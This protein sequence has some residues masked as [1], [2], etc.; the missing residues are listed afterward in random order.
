[1]KL[2]KLTNRISQM[3]QDILR[4]WIKEEAHFKQVHWVLWIDTN[5][6]GITQIT[7]IVR[8]TMKREIIYNNHQKN[9]IIITTMLE[10]T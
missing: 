9:N 5:I 8:I 6:K 10:T 7:L 3:H 1:M 4:D 2:E